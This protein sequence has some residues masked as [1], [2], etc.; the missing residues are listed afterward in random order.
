MFLHRYYY[1][2]LLSWGA[3]ISL[4][5]GATAFVFLF[6][7]PIFF[8]MWT[9]TLSNFGNHKLGWGYRTYN[10]ND[11]S[12]NSWWLAILFWGEG[13]HNNHH[14]EPRNWSFNRKWWEFDMSG[15]VIK[16]VRT[17]KH[18]A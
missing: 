16:L 9:M 10:T 8:Q 18:E 7:M 17:N 13:W 5:F 2:L 1:W 12:V 6:A 14:A 4:A 11:N 3:F 15:Q